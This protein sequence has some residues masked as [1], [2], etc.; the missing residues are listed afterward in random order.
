ML[1][2]FAPAVIASGIDL[3]EMGQSMGELFLGEGDTDS[4]THQ[5]ERGEITLE[6]LF[7]SF[8]EREQQI[9][10]AF[11]TPGA[12]HFMM[13]GFEAHADMFAFVRELSN[14]GIQTA[15]VSNNVREWQPA[16][17]RVLAEPELFDELLFSWQ[18][19]CRKPGPAI[20]Q[21]A[22]DR[23]GVD[24]ATVVFLDDS[25]NMVTGAEAAGLKGVQ[26]DDH[27]VAIAETRELLG[28]QG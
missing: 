27:A 9:M 28:L 3:N 7:A 6:E 22:C 15:V 21:L 13:D 18:V 12:D 24:P 1:E 23:L 14:A 4:P 19:G 26:V 25:A 16:W 17:D 2:A 10:R 11:L 5:L 8:G 20:Y